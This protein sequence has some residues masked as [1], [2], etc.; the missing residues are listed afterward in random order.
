M[1]GKAGRT[2]ATVNPSTGEEICRVSEALV[3]DVDAAVAA[4]GAA[5]KRGSPWRTLDASARGR[6]LLKLADLVE[7]DGA[8]LA[9]LE[10]LD[11]G[12]PYGDALGID[13]A[14]AHKCFRYFGGWADKIHGKTI[15]I[16]GA[17]LTYTRL[18]PVG[19]VGQIVP[20]NFS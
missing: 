9:A 10:T 13:V 19:V 11:N 7:R 17:F 6:L 2:F 4:A 18:E 14:L 12:K 20:W 3:E 16:D 5:F 8:T 1:A 15:P